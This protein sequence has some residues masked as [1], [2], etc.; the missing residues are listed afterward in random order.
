[1]EETKVNRYAIYF[2]I[3]RFVHIYFKI[4]FTSINSTSILH[5]YKGNSYQA[6]NVV[7]ILLFGFEIQLQYLQNICY[8]FQR[9]CQY[10]EL[11]MIVSL[12]SYM[13][14]FFLT[15][16]FFFLSCVIFSGLT[17]GLLN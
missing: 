11:K 14:T 17:F 2:L 9:F 5:G 15:C 1:V 13:D 4:I 7:G 16:D 10:V 3:Y 12:F 6:R 8:L